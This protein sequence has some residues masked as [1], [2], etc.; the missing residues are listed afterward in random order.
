MFL[1][2][3]NLKAFVL[4]GALGT[5]ASPITTWAGAWSSGGGNAVVCLDSAGKISSAEVLDLYEGRVLKGLSYPA[6]TAPYL[7]QAVAA[8]NSISLKPGLPMFVADYIPKVA[9]KIKFLPAGAG[10]RPINDSFEIVVPKGCQIMQAARFEADD[11]VYVD[12]DIWSRLNE[13]NRAA[14]VMH[15]SLYW[16]LRLYGDQTS[17]R[18]RATVAHAFAGSKFLDIY[19]RLPSSIEIC[20]TGLGDYGLPWA[21]FATYPSPDGKGAIAQFVTFGGS[22]VISKTTAFLINATWP[23]SQNPPP[24]STLWFGLL[25]SLVDTTTRY[26]IRSPSATNPMGFIGEGQNPLGMPTRE[27]RCSVGSRPN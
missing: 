20:Q 19:D 11:I 21:S 15:E 25:D 8:A 16:V 2:G 14:L 26:L 7:E 13:Q 4:M 23:L 17:R 5:L 10:L 1:K 12:S 22:I 24:I 27:F 18:T 3:L 6:S 9:A